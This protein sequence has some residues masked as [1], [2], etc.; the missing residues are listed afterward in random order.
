MFSNSKK[1]DK[2]PLDQDV[3]NS[4]VKDY[5]NEPFFVEKAEASKKIIEKYGLPKQL[6]ANKK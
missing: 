4:K 1:G 3:L 6:I 5:G 2:K